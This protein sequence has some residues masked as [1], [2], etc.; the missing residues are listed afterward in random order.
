MGS[1]PWPIIKFP[2][3]P[4]IDFAGRI[5]D[6]NGHPEWEVGQGAFVRIGETH[7]LALIGSYS[8]EVL[9]Y[10]DPFKK[11]RTGQGALAEYLK[12]SVSLSAMIF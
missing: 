4:E 1:I 5:A 10:L 9:G 11:L 6:A 12:I 2:S 3:I 8:E 7:V